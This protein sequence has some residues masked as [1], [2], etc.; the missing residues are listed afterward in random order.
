M[1]QARVWFN[2]LHTEGQLSKK[3]VAPRGQLATGWTIRQT[4][5]ACS[6]GRTSP[7]IH[8]LL[9][10]HCFPAGL[11]TIYTSK[12]LNRMCHLTSCL[13]SCYPPPRNCQWT[14]RRQSTS[15]MGWPWLWL[16]CDTISEYRGWPRN[17]PTHSSGYRRWRGLNIGRNCSILQRIWSCRRPP[18]RPQCG[19]LWVLGECLRCFP[20]CFIQTSRSP[21]CRDHWMRSADSHFLHGLR[22]CTL[23]LYGRSQCDLLVGQ[24]RQSSTPRSSAHFL[25]SD[26]AARTSESLWFSE[27]KHRWI[28]RCLNNTRRTLSFYPAQLRMPSDEREP[29]GCRLNTAA[30]AML[31]PIQLCELCTVSC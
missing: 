11:R 24:A 17:R 8:A 14:L 4:G 19:R 27:Y 1:G 30:T 28:F 21:E 10:S 9:A 16:H 2:K 12:Y 13:P 22:K 7:R 15:R 25:T 31:P 5:S 18:A 29:T 20:V 26:L 6:R 23:S 3:S